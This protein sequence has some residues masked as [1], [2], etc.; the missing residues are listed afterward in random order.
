MPEQEL[1]ANQ[2]AAELVLP[3]RE[4]ES[5]VKKTEVTMKVAKKV[6]SE[7][8]A[9]LTAATL[10]CV[11]VTTE[12]CAVAQCRWLNQMVSPQRELSLLR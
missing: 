1:A 12:R 10:K 3:Y 8:E 5:F 6:S 9:S 7:F 2:F 4:V 11:D